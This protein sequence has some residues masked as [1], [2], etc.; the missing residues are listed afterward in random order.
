[1]VGGTRVLGRES[2]NV[3]AII[4]PHLTNPFFAKA[5]LMVMVDLLGFAVLFLVIALIAYAMGA[6]GFAGFS[7]EIAKVL[8]VV[9]LVLFVLSLIFG[10]SIGL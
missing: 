4:L 2:R 6:K 8:I 3:L 7:M 1:M 9:F 5:D 10:L